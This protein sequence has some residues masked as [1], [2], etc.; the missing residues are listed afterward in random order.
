LN[1]QGL[2]AKRFA[3]KLFQEPSSLLQFGKEPFLGLKRRAV[4]ATP[5]PAKLDRMLQVQ[6]LVVDDVLDRVERNLG[7]VEDTADH[8]GIVSGIVMA[9]AVACVIAAPSH[10]R[11]SQKAKEK[12]L[13]QVLKNCIQIVGPALRGIDLLASS[14]LADEMSLGDKIAAGNIAPIASGMSSVNALTV[15]LGEKNVRDGANHRFGSAFQKIGKSNQKFAFPQA[16]GVVNVG[17]GEEIDGQFWDWSARPQLAVSFLKNS[18]Q[19]LSHV[20]EIS[21]ESLR[22][23]EFLVLRRFV[24]FGEQLAMVL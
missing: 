18:K 8:N 9:K 14:H 13:V 21:T 19:P 22:F 16:N 4:D 12:T 2:T 23:D 6:H 5:A 11:A 17:K 3:S 1:R 20:G 10:L 7:M 15:H 24:L